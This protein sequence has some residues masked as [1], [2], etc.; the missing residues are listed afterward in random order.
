MSTTTT[1]TITTQRPARP[2]R[3]S[4]HA[5]M[6]LSILGG[7]CAGA[8]GD[9]RLPVREVTVF[10]D[11]HA[12]TLRKGA[13]PTDA[14]GDVEI[15]DL[16]HAILG[17]FW[18]FSDEEGATL[19]AVT[20]GT[21]TVNGTAEL[22]SLADVLGACAGS[23]V[24]VR[25]ND[26]REHR[27]VFR[28]FTGD[29]AV[30]DADGG[31]LLIPTQGITDVRVL[32]RESSRIA[33]TRTIERQDDRLLMDLDWGRRE[34]GK[35]ASVGIMCV[36]KG[37]RWIPSYR[38]TL[39][40]EG[41]AKVELQATLVNEL[42][43]L[44]DVSMNLVVGVPTFAFAETMDP[45]A[46]QDQIAQLGQ[47]FEADARSAG[48]FSNSIMT[49]TMSRMSERRDM[50]YDP[51][52]GDGG[53]P[54]PEM[55]GTDRAED[56]YVFSVSHVTLKKGERMTLPVTTTSVSYE[57][58]YLLDIPLSP[59]EFVWQ[60]WNWQQQQQVG[61][62]LEKPTARHAVRMK[63][64]GPH[65]FTTAPALI[66]SNGRVVAQG[67]MKYA[68]VGAKAKLELTDAV[69]IQ[70]EHGERETS[71]AMNDTKF[72][73]STFHR[74]NLEGFIDLTNHKK[75]PV[76]V[77]VTRYVIGHLDE[78][79]D[80]VT[81]QGVSPFSDEGFRGPRHAWW[82]GWYG[83]PWWYVR[84]NAVQKLSWDAEI[85]PGECVHAKWTWH[86]YWQ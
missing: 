71:R 44:D 5:A 12:L 16:P 29:R 80:G 39:D 48:A 55:G 14:R 10:K 56:L 57:D 69:D 64:D 70:V 4:A 21:R 45:M 82:W 60:Y 41:R 62:S 36:E 65:P 31:T 30:F 74:A 25:M 81:S 77:E 53:A 18:P 13:M 24:V 22:S 9:E 49:Q 32:D 7:M 63:N 84:M 72:N 79:S 6:A 61:A 26:G 75:E 28:R 23:G 42:V 37:I 51:V 34:P 1:R 17:T 19:R 27:G 85:K 20:A 78:T 58:V 35:D 83:W 47:Y 33:W 54:S 2:R 66:M 11:G 86:S 8:L 38:V 40:G 59:P 46:M 43:D 52:G 73:G 3:A 15:D 67:M 76:K 50:G 68:S